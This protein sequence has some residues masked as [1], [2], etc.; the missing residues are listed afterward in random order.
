MPARALA[1]LSA[2]SYG[3]FPWLR[4]RA[5]ASDERAPGPLLGPRLRRARSPACAPGHQSGT[6][7]HVSAHVWFRPARALGPYLLCCQCIGALGAVR[8]AAARSATALAGRAPRRMRTGVN[9]HVF[10][11]TNALASRI[12][13]AGCVGARS[14]L[15]TR[16]GRL[17][18]QDLEISHGAYAQREPRGGSVVWKHG[19]S[20]SEGRHLVFVARQLA[21][22]GWRDS[23][24]QD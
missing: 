3:V 24:V 13:S 2:G 19:A 18:G 4:C 20:V 22:Q 8:E 14:R 12:A 17:R 11:G 23:S 15:C 9:R 21:F 10:W 16:V 1:T 6:H 5:K 7:R